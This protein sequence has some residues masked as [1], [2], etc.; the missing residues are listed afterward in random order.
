M[1]NDHAQTDGLFFGKREYNAGAQRQRTPARAL[2]F[3]LA[4]TEEHAM[5][6][7]IVLNAEGRR[8]FVLQ[9]HN[10]IGRHP[11]NTIQVMDL[12]VSKEHCH[13]VLI[14]GRHVLRDLGSLNGTYV[15]GE[16]VQ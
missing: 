10:S 1:R 4:N 11:N 7:V 5:T 3:V 6:R 2:P 8:E 13:I 14:N 9:P 12:G 16:R 15:N